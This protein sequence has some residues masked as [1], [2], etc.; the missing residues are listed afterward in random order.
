[1][2]IA[3]PL[4]P[5]DDNLNE[6]ANVFA[7]ELSSA[8]GYPL[9]E[10]EE[11][12]RDFYLEY[13][14]SMPERRRALAKA[15]VAHGLDA[16]K[17]EP[18]NTAEVFFHDGSALVLLIGYRLAGGDPNTLEFLDWRKGCW[19]ALRNGQRVPTPRFYERALLERL[20][21]MRAAKASPSEVV[22]TIVETLSENN[23]PRSNGLVML[24]LVFPEVP[25]DVVR[26]LGALPGLGE[27]EPLAE[28]RVNQLLGPWFPT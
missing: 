15:F 16:E 28:A 25:L 2:T 13:E 12:V 5:D 17:A 27:G 14:R 10:A 11:H 23:A 4:A 7:R 26:E 8:F 20:R 22:S 18:M 3:P 1:M 21:A 9:P 6:T 19:D 24:S